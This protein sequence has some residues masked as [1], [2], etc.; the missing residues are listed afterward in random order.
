MSNPES[1]PLIETEQP[2]SVASQ[3]EKR[4]WQLI[5]SVGAE[6]GSIS[7]LGKPTEAGW[8]YRRGVVDRSAALIDE[9]DIRHTSDIVATWPAALRLMDRYQ[10]ARLSPIKMHPAFADK[11]MVAVRDRLV[12]VP[13][14]DWDLA[15]WGDAARTAIVLPREHR[16]NEVLA[17]AMGE[18]MFAAQWSDDSDPAF[19]AVAIAAFELANAEHLDRVAQESLTREIVYGKRAAVLGRLFGKPV[20]PRAIRWLKRV[21]WLDMTRDDW[22]TFFTITALRNP[23]ASLGRLLLITPTLLRQYFQIPEPFRVPAVLDVLR[24]FTVSNE[25]WTR[26]GQCLEKAEPSWRTE[27]IRLA[28]AIDGRGDFWDFYFRC[29][30]SYWRPFEVPYAFTNSE[31]LE[32]I[33][34]PLDLDAEGMRMSNCLG[35]RASDVQS[36]R[37]VYFR[38][39]DQDLVNAELVRRVKS[40][41][42]GA[43]LGPRNSAVPAAVERQIRTE[44]LRLANAAALAGETN[45]SIA[46][47]DYVGVLCHDAQTTFEPEEIKELRDPLEAIRGNSRSWADAAYAIFSTENGAYV[48]FMSS[49]DD[50]EYLVEVSSH[51]YRPDLDLFLTDDAVD[52]LDKTGFVWPTGKRNFLRWF[53]VTSSEDV[54][55]MAELALGILARVF[56]HSGESSVNV[57]VRVP[58]R[59]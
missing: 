20:A 14:G 26:M 43:I 51:E 28:E 18:P 48:Q 4:P 45:H 6:G 33:A 29:E 7:L 15:K 8:T 24:N 27:L 35:K 30:G 3:C 22:K 42:P 44:L 40:W 41:V 21:R 59:N 49:P 9:R 16:L 19:Q 32:V 12:A 56:G 13:R 10:W 5:V 55:Q 57:R 52:L 39:R 31:F 50:E 17:R 46:A 11:V 1:D 37:R 47:D 36:G 38:P 2:R 23:V 25:R 53:S 58:G 34:S 54:Q